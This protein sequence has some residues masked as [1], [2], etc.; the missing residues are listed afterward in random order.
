M[1][2]AAAQPS[3]PA[4]ANG[5]A[6]GDTL[7]ANPHG[8]RLRQTAAAR[9]VSDA[10]LANM[11]RS[12]VGEGPIPSERARAALAT[13]LAKI[14]EEIA[15]RTVELLDM[16]HPASGTQPQGTSDTVTSVDFGTLEPQQAA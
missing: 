7:Q 5:E 10:D 15:T 16:F 12:A 2:G 13:M 6:D 9:G 4:T 11:I 3:A 8:E 1:S 14:S